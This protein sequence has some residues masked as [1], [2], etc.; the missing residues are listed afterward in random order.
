MID[1]GVNEVLIS[2]IFIFKTFDND[3]EDNNIELCV[4]LH[5][6]CTELD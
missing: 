6:N 4:N 2:F 5:Q 1:K 3:I